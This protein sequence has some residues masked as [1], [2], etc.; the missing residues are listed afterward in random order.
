MNF[1]TAVQIIL[2]YEGGHVN[3]PHDKGGE[4]NFGI[5]KKQ[6]PLLDI[7]NL[8]IEEAKHL[9]KKDYWNA[10]KCDELPSEIRLVIFDS[11]VNQ[12]VL[13]ATLL[14]QEVL[15][16]VKDGIIGPITIGKSYETDTTQFLINFLAH[17][18]LKY[19]AL[20]DF[21]RY[22]RGWIRRLFDVMLSSVI[23]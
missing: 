20:E 13:T 5:S 11:S 23:K 4:T 1:E 15:G 3:D 12:G 8:T 2:K 18:A 14:L 10:C 17:R 19:M 9:Y 16:A 21:H 7:K 22:G 6:Y